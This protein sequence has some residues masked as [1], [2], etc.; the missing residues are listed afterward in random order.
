[1]KKLNGLEA[2]WLRQGLKLVLE[3]ATAEIE[4][5]ENMGRRHIM[6]TGYVTQEIKQL[7]DKISDMTLKKAK[8]WKN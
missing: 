3:Q 1:M 4:D 6:T 8:K 5:V 2:Y 7:Q